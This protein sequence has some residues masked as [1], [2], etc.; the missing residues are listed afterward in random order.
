MEL[1]IAVLAFLCLL[2]TLTFWDSVLEPV[3][4]DF[5]GENASFGDV[6]IG[7]FIASVAG[8]ALF[9]F[10]SKKVSMHAELR[11]L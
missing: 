9:L 11:I 8:V 1:K 5:V 10:L 4:L 6:S 3:Y 7:Y 2:F